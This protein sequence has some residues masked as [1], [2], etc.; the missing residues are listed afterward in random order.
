MQIKIAFKAIFLVDGGNSR[1]RKRKAHPKT[2]RALS[3]TPHSIT[4]A[5]TAIPDVLE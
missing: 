5:G 3:G 1:G 4:D 2:L